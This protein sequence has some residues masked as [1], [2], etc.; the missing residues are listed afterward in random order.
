MRPRDPDGMVNREDPD[1]GLHCLFRPVYPNVW[2][3]AGGIKMGLILH[4][5]KFQFYL[6]DVSSNTFTLSCYTGLRTES[7]IF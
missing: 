1:L 5:T 4:T 3:R 7:P 6:S 2:K